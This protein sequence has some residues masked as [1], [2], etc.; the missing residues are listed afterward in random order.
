MELS[1]LSAIWILT[2]ND[3][4]VAPLPSCST[5]ISGIY[6]TQEYGLVAGALLDPLSCLLPC[7]VS[8]LKIE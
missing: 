3:D 8:S 5:L 6:D 7:S 1:T 4:D 2:V